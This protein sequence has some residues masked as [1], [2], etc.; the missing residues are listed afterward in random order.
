MTLHDTKEFDN[1]LRGRADEDLTFSTT[2]SVDNVILHAIRW[3]SI[4]SGSAIYQAVI[5]RGDEIIREAQEEISNAQGQTRGP[6]L[7]EV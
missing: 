2:L 5:L 4:S 1:D 3:M 6:F 7:E